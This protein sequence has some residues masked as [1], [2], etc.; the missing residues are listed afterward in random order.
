MS[1]RAMWAW[2][3]GWAV[4]FGLAALCGC[5]ATSGAT[6]RF[7]RLLTPE[8]YSFR[9]EPEIQRLTVVTRSGD[10]IEHE[11]VGPEVVAEWRLAED[12]DAFYR[13]QIKAKWPGR[14]MDLTAGTPAAP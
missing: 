8:L 7:E 1:E 12:R 9:Y 10:V 5:M 3:R 6:G 4:C 14:P 2:M 11:G 13:E